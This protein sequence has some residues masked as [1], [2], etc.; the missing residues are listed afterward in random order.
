MGAASDADKLAL[1]FFAADRATVELGRDEMLGAVEGACHART[2]LGD[3]EHTAPEQVLEQRPRH[4]PVPGSFEAPFH[5]IGNGQIL[6]GERAAAIDLLQDQVD[7]IRVL[8]QKA[9]EAIRT[10]WMIV[11]PV[12]QVRPQL[13]RDKRGLVPP[14]LGELAPAVGEAV[15]QRHLVRA[16]SR[17]EHLVMGRD[18]HVDE[19]ELK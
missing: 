13:D 16:E 19:V 6:G 3:R 1:G 18:N 5:P 14:L 2:A 4:R 8:V 12:A 10:Q 11:A 9:V 15:E 7:V 17:V